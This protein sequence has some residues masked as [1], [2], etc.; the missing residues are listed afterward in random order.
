MSKNVYIDKLD[1][2]LGDYNN[3]CHRTITMKPIDVKDNIYILILRKKLMI[4]ILNLKLEIMQEFLNTKIFLLKDT[5][6]TG[7]K[8]FL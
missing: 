1:D 3:I 4:K 7:L 6:Q 5:Q 8:K 2:I